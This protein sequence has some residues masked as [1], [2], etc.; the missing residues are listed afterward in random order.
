M[1]YF[2]YQAS[3]RLAE[4]EAAAS[5]R[6]QAQE[7]QQAQELENSDQVR[8]CCVSRCSLCGVFD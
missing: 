2:C 4:E 1:I 8:Y 6:G 7:A 5:L 3:G